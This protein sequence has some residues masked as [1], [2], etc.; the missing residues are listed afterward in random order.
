MDMIGRILRLR[1]RNNKSEY[2][3]ARIMGLSRNTLPK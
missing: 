1:G 3:I 2:E